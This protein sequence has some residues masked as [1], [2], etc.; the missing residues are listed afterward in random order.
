VRRARPF[1]AGLIALSLAACGGGRPAR[2][3][4][5]ARVTGAATF[6]SLSPDVYEPCGIERSG[7]AVFV[8]GCSG[9]VVRVSGGGTTGRAQ[10]APGE[11][12]ALD[13]L[14][15]GDGESVWV[16]YA[17]GSGS[18]R[19]GSVARLDPA[20]GAAGQAVSVGRSIPADALAVGSTLWVAATDG[21]LVAVEDRT[22]R[23]VASGPPLLRVLADG[24]RLW[25]VAENGDVVERTSSGET[26]R[27]FEGVM[28]N[29]IG[30][31]AGLG[32][33]WLASA[34]RGL[35]RIDAET[36]NVRRVAVTETVNAIEPCGGAVWIAQ[37]DVGVRALDVNGRVV[38]TVALAV[39]PRYLA[40][41]GDRLVVVSEDGRVGTVAAAP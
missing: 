33:I 7:D 9:S 28:P 23:R 41:T 4:R 8:V 16:L 2:Q 15:G 22:A 19:R 30:A 13:A 1:L 37:P 10:K 18:A 21:A 39:A 17:T 38:R 31:A 5:P 3:P 36:G 25:T 32:R 26:S 6:T 35:V 34:A 24:G 40:C 29:A 20:T 11:I 14:A 12:V 27:T